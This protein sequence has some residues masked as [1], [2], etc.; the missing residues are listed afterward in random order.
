MTRLIP[1]AVFLFLSVYYFANVMAIIT[2]SIRITGG[3]GGFETVLLLWALAPWALLVVALAPS[4]T[5]SDAE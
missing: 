4:Q 3:F 2:D 5:R 1:I